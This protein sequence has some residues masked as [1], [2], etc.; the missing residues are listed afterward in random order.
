[1]KKP[2]HNG[3]TAVRASKRPRLS[4]GEPWQD[5][6]LF[7]TPPWGT[8]AFM[9]VV[10]PLVDERKMS[11]LTFWEPCAGL[12]HMSA[13][14]Q[15]RVGHVIQSDV[16]DYGMNIATLDFLGP[17]AEAMRHD[18][19][20]ICTNPPFGSALDILERAL[21]LAKPCGGVALLLRHSWAEGQ[22]RH[23]RVFGNPERQPTLIATFSERLP[24][25][26]GGYDPALS[27][28]TCYSWFVWALDRAGN[29]ARISHNS[30]F[31]PTIIIPPG[32]KD[33]LTRPQDKIHAS[34]FI[35]GWVPPS[36][37]KKSGKGQKSL[38]ELA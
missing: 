18:A 11:E 9:E 23:R 29:V 33:R 4:D 37:L 12:L 17:E 35:K 14:L 25:C 2:A 38:L 21:T 8:R 26:E 16:F 1:M 32:Q 3:G 24:M 28:A 7:P 10:F 30:P 15:E 31:I 36:T 13:V 19:D 20:W 34:R 27:S 6:E 5:L 22:E